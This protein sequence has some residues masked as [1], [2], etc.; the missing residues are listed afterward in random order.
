MK[1]IQD[2]IILTGHTTHNEMMGNQSQMPID[3][4]HKSNYFSMTKLN[5]MQGLCSTST[6]CSLNV[7]SEQ[8]NLRRDGK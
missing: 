6:N 2:C 3:K 8:S 7:I 4:V 5:Y 1:A